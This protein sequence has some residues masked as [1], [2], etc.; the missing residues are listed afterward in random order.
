MAENEEAETGTVLADVLGEADSDDPVTVAGVAYP[1]Y[2]LRLRDFGR[3]QRITGEADMSLGT[4][5]GMLGVVLCNMQRTNP[6][7]TLDEVEA[8]FGDIADDASMTAFTTIFARVMRV[9]GLAGDP[10]ESSGGGAEKKGAAAKAKPKASKST[11][12]T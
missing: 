8:K 3:I 1:I 6:D 9:S 4:F 12:S 7:L 11:A 5:D 2:P 10:S